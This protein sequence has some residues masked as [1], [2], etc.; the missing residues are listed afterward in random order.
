LEIKEIKVV[1]ARIVPGGEFTIEATGKLEEQ[2]QDGAYVDAVIKVGLV[3]LLRKQYDL[4]DTIAKKEGNEI[5]CPI[6]A[7][8]IK[9]IRLCSLTRRKIVSFH[10][11]TLVYSINR[12]LRN[13]LFQ[14]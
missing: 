8:D 13:L 6:P 9:V 10:L 1:P 5:R 14:A 2:I 4:C 12:Y 7:G 11:I 3:T